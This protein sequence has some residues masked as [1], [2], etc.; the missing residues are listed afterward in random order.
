M[1]AAESA[2]IRLKQPEESLLQG[3]SGADAPKLDRS[4]MWAAP[5][6]ESESHDPTSSPLAGPPSEAPA[7]LPLET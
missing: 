4:A 1:V 5:A 3:V 6:E 2:A 7:E